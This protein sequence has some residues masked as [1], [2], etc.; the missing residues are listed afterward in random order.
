MK[1]LTLLVE[2]SLA[3]AVG[4]FLLEKGAA[5]LTYLDG[6]DTPIFEPALHTMPLWQ[7]TAVVALFLEEDALDEKKVEKWLL[8]IQQRFQLPT[9]PSYTLEPVPHKPW[10]RVWMEEFKPM[11]FGHG[12]WIC[13]SW[14]PPPHPEAT[15]IFL[16]PG[17]AFGTGTHPTTALCLK[18][19]AAQHLKGKTVIDYGCGSGILAMAAAKR[20]AQRV[21][22][23]DLHPQALEATVENAKHNGVDL[24]ITTGTPE[25]PLPLAQVLLANILAEPL[26]ALAPLFARCIEP[27]GD[28]VLSGLLTS[29]VPD[30]LKRYE[31]WFHSLTSVTQEDW[32]LIHGIRN[33]VC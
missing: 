33:S 19:L 9:T 18:W 20:G 21:F 5:S 8:Q 28:L 29:Q 14:C 26:H 22:A 10:E 4:D 27:S 32:A 6:G 30:I 15:N 11:D 7:C 1:Q 25:T 17:L 12:L 23:I 13:P 2:E 31:P 24:L 16:D 3:E